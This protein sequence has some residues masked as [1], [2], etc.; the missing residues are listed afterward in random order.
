MLL[1]LCRVKLKS[2][3]T[4]PSLCWAWQF[5]AWTVQPGKFSLG[6]H[7]YWQEVLWFSGWTDQL[8][9]ILFHLLFYL[10]MLLLYITAQNQL[11]FILFYLLFYLTML[12]LYITAQNQCVKERYVGHRMTYTWVWVLCVLRSRGSG[13]RELPGRNTDQV[14]LFG[15]ICLQARFL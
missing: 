13:V 15:F 4:Q 1:S 3:A 9:L 14:Q 8:I 12:L 6:R 5:T 11:I 2:Q 10:N 7:L